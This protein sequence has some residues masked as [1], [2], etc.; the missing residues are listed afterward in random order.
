M[1]TRTLLE[2]KGKGTPNFQKKNL[3]VD[4]ILTLENWGWWWWPR[5]S[6]CAKR[7]HS[8]GLFPQ[9]RLANVNSR[10][11]SRICMVIAR[12]LGL[13]TLQKSAKKKGICGHTMPIWGGSWQ[14]R[15]AP[16]NSLI[17]H[18]TFDFEGAVSHCSYG[19]SEGESGDVNN[20]DGIL[21]KLWVKSEKMSHLTQYKLV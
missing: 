1:L 7:V 14:S 11:D 21:C 16:Q 9:G 4:V 10:T 19:D 5:R 17:W 15:P 12:A 6:G 2:S 20:D 3:K 13:K 8:Q 18:L